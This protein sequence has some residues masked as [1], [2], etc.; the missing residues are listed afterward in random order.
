MKKQ[1]VVGFLF[2]ID[3]KSLVVIHKNRPDYLAGKVIVP[4]GKVE[5]GETPKDAMTREFREET[6]VHINGW[7]EFAVLQTP[8]FEI[9]C[10]MHSS[11]ARVNRVR[12]MTDERV[13][14]V[15]IN[16]LPPNM[17]PN[18]RWMITMALTFYAGEHASAFHIQEVYA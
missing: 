2:S 4:G 15:D 3:A 14:V 7:K 13:E 8:E 17:L 1:L 5:P 12:T 6:G 9:F 11:T 18:A 16:N 10:F